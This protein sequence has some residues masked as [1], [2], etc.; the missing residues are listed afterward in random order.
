MRRASAITL[1]ELCD[2]EDFVL[3]HTS[4]KYLKYHLEKTVGG[5]I[6]KVQRV[7]GKPTLDENA[8][9]F[10]RLLRK[11][12]EQIHAALK[13]MFPFLNLRKLWLDCL[14]PLTLRQL[15]KFGLP[16][17][18]FEDLPRLNYLVT[19]CCSLI[20]FFHPGFKPLFM[21]SDNEQI[22]LATII[23]KR[24]FL[25]NPLLHPEIWPVELNPR[26]NSTSWT[27][28]SFAEMSS[29]GFMEFPQL[30]PETLTPTVFEIASGANA[31][32]QANSSLTYM[33][34]LLIKGQN[35]TRQ[36]TEDALLDPPNEWK[37]KYTDISTPPVL[38]DEARFGTWSNVRIVGCKI[39]PSNKSSSPANFH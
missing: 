31:I 14:K 4:N 9:K 25:E 6:R 17:D 32:N 39:P 5:K 37:L 26:S 2:Q 10:T 35:L 3:L 13:Q 29:S 1:A 7:A 24:L 8:V 36:E 27:E 12:Q 11:T 33:K 15:T 16:G 28:I 21:N 18:R 20:N 34:Q 23:L 22:R 38:W 19:V 30:T